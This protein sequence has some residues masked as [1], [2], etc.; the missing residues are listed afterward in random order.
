MRV[1][2]KRTYSARAL[3]T[4]RVKPKKKKRQ[5]EVN[6]TNKT[7]RNLDES[8]EFEDASAL[9]ESVLD[10]QQNLVA[11]AQRNFPVVA[12]QF[13]GNLQGDPVSLIATGR[14]P[15]FEKL[16]D[17]PQFQPPSNEQQQF[18][19]VGAAQPQLTHAS[20]VTRR[21]PFPLREPTLSLSPNLQVSPGRDAM[22]TDAMETNAQRN[23]FVGAACR[24]PAFGASNQ[25]FGS[26][27]WSR[28]CG[29]VG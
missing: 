26:V 22:S 14:L 8:L 21:Q 1:L 25:R 15:N 20:Q 27:K 17:A 29:K 18:C 10:E 12:Q 6:P 28:F 24:L 11:F 19:A 4:P 16:S 3:S 13:S 9:S 5:V 23:A 7:L 2:R